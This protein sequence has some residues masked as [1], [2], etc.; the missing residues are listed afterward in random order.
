[1][2]RDSYGPGSEDTQI[3]DEP[4]SAVLG[5]QAD[6]V[7]GC[8][9]GTDES[10]GARQYLA[11]IGIPAHVVVQTVPLEAQSRQRAETV[12]L[13]TV[14]LGKVAVVQS[15]CSRLWLDA[16]LYYALSISWRLA[17]ISPLSPVFGGEGLG[18][19]GGLASTAPSPQ[20][21]PP[22][23]GER[24]PDWLRLVAGDQWR[25]NYFLLKCRGWFSSC[26]WVS[27]DRAHLRQ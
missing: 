6:A 17:K 20:P 5:Q 3:R 11:A 2:E 4:F 16:I 10:G 25:N 22:K 12:G 1:M 21:S 19:R 18:V 15:R 26:R 24:E 8:D 7:T 14:Q 9:A 23:T 13:K 27:Y